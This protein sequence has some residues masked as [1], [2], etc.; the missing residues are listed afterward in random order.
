MI[1][2]ERTFDSFP[3]TIALEREINALGKRKIFP[4]RKSGPS[5][6]FTLSQLCCLLDN[7]EPFPVIEWYED[8]DEKHYAFRGE[9]SNPNKKQKI[10]ENVDFSKTAHTKDGMIRSK[11]VKSQLCMLVLKINNVHYERQ[12]CS[13]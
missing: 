12:L 4:G 10:S 8:D 1:R 7:A 11:K 3:A 13:S 2:P 6:V 9:Y 5:E